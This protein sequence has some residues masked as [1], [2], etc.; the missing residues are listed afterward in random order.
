MA[1]CQVFFLIAVITIELGIRVEALFSKF[2]SFG[3]HSASQIRVY[4]GPQGSE[5]TSGMSTEVVLAVSPDFSHSC[6]APL[7]FQKI[8]V[9]LSPLSSCS[10]PLSLPMANT[11]C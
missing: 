9:C 8:W 2:Q 6:M 5:G 7:A 4:H 1:C 10:H 11:C 3:H